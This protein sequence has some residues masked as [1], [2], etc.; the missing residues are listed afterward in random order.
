MSWKFGTFGT[1]LQNNLFQNGELRNSPLF[2][3]VDLLSTNIN[4]GRDHGLKPY[5]HYVRMCHNIVV[6]NFNDL[7]PLMNGK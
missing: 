4:R 2:R 1:E 6:N 3:A 7:R 5:V